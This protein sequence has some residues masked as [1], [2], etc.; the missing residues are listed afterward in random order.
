MSHCIGCA[1]FSNYRAW[2]HVVKLYR[3]LILRLQKNLCIQVVCCLHGPFN[4][5][6]YHQCRHGLRDWLYE[7]GQGKQMSWQKC[8]VYATEIFHCQEQGRPKHI[9]SFFFFFTIHR[10]NNAKIWLDSAPFVQFLHSTICTFQPLPLQLSMHP[11][12]SIKLQ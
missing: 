11:S 1:I 4:N 7:L 5:V 2:L 10:W 9:V 8:D 6:S 12:T 3:L